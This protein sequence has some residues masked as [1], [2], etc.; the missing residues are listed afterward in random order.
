MNL[1][2]PPN[3]QSPVTPSQFEYVNKPP[4]DL[5]QSDK[6]SKIKDNLSTIVILISAPLLAIILSVFVFR[7]YQVDGPSMLTTL[8]DKDRLI[9]NK[10]PKTF[11]KIAGKDYIPDRYDIVVFEHKGQFSS[12]GIEEKQIIK[13]VIAL[14][15][16]RIVIKDGTAT[17]YNAENPNGFKVDELGPH[18][19]VIKTTAGDI[20][21]T[22]KE[23]E[24][25][26]MGDNRGNSLDSRAIGTI[27]ADDIVG[28]LVLRIY[29]FEDWRGF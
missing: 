14:P 13:R 3:Q 6:K 7:T 8:H 10:L 26:L 20:D 5:Y 1:H 28:K 27:K 21:E 9:I 29:P 11:S 19:K 17:V 18:A 16:E 25:F 24:I 4:P 15:G 22:V 12:R 2:E 23:G